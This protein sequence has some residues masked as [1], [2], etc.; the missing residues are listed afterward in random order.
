MLDLEEQEVAFVHHV[1]EDQEVAIDDHCDGD[2]PGHVVEHGECD[3][4]LQF[5]KHD[6]EY[7]AVA[8]GLILHCLV[9]HGLVLNQCHE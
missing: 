2:H 9:L 5:T 1:E 8:D 7:L 6:I 3:N 4:L